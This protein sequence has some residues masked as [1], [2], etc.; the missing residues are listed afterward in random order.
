MMALSASALRLIAAVGVAA[1]AN[2]PAFAAT[3]G[4]VAIDRL[5]VQGDYGYVDFTAPFLEP[6]LNGVI[7]FNLALEGG[8]AALSVLLTAKASGQPLR[9]VDFSKDAQ[10][11]CEIDL[12]QL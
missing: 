10:G 8:K 7:Y 2:V 5:G 4:P 11:R 3:Q 12:V 1:F 6:C 9:R